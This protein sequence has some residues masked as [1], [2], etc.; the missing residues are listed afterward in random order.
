[1]NLKKGKAMNTK[2]LMSLILALVCSSSAMGFNLGDA[3]SSATGVSLGT[4]CLEIGS[5]WPEHVL[6]TNPRSVVNFKQITDY[7]ELKDL[8]SVGGKVS[9]S[10]A[11]ITA[12]AEG[13][14]LN[15]MDKSSRTT[16]II[17]KID[18]S[19]EARLDVDFNKYTPITNGLN[20][21]SRVLYTSDN[22]EKQ[23]VFFEICGDSYV[24]SAKMT[25]GLLVDVSI[26]FKNSKAR[27]SFEAEISGEIKKPT[28]SL[29]VSAALKLANENTNGTAEI[30]ISALQLGGSMLAVGG[31]IKK[32]DNGK[33]PIAQCGGAGGDSSC[34]DIMTG[35]LD[36]GKDLIHQFT[37]N[38]DYYYT[39]PVAVSYLSTF[40]EKGNPEA[41]ANEEILSD[42]QAD[43]EE[44]KRI[45]A[46]IQEFKARIGED[47]TSEGYETLDG[48]SKTVI[49]PYLDIYKNNQALK[50]CAQSL[51]NKD[52]AGLKD[53]IQA[54]KKDKAVD[55]KT[56]KVNRNFNIANG[57]GEKMLDFIRD[58]NYTVR[59]LTLRDLTYEVPKFE[60]ASCSLQPVYQPDL[61][62]SLALSCPKTASGGEVTELPEEGIRLKIG[63]DQRLSFDGFVYAV[64]EGGEKYCF[65]Y[66]GTTAGAIPP[67]EPGT[68]KIKDPEIMY[69]HQTRLTDG[70][71]HKLLCPDADDEE[72]WTLV[73]KSNVSPISGRFSFVQQTLVSIYPNIIR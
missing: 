65:K 3:Y 49:G 23:K 73:T 8:L 43:Y 48:Y 57:R 52:C 25:G 28:M 1:M 54:A 14:Y 35:I 58:N 38:S 24:G 45:E 12:E 53:K 4:T 46:V 36:Y 26:K 13:E 67:S 55:K 16:H 18:A 6:V 72:A 19:S 31:I 50:K 29:G 51:T 11:M 40:G 70:K 47:K 44:L 39:E 15:S 5:K 62:N 7:E 56:G 61:P 34:G 21:A 69:H 32:G 37:K 64:V 22:A 2:R 59:L 17:Y 9:F 63:A 60:G 30:N 68:Y 42:I 33:Y 71:G 20:A 27:E 10:N 41:G 66:P